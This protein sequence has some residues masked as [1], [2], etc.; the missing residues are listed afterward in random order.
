MY[1]SISHSIVLGLCGSLTENKIEFN[2]SFSPAS[3]ESYAIANENFA[4][5]AEADKR[6]VTWEN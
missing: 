6:E 2:K 4:T 3:N 1:T 5:Y